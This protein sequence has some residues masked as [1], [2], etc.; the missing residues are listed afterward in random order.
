MRITIIAG[1]LCALGLTAC[2]TTDSERALTGAAAGA[3]VA[4]AADE[5][6]VTGAALGG[7][8]GALSC[9]VAPDAPNCF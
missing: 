3:L 6:L 2:G 4:G 8:V 5:N 1:A 7:L 9:D